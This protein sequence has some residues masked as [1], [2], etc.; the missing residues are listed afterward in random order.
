MITNDILK[1]IK[2]IEICTKRLL[3]GSLVG[4]SRSAIKGSG[5][6]FDQ[7][8]EYQIGDDVRFLDW[9]S[10]ARTGKLLVKQYIEERNRT[11]ILAVDISGSSFF[12]SSTVPKWDLF[13]QI[14]AVLTLVAEYG[15]DNVS[16]I[17]FSDELEL[18][19]PPGRGRMHIQTILHHIFSWKP[20]KKQTCISAVLK[21]LA[22][23]KRTD[24]VVFLVSDFIVHD[25]EPLL[26]VI[27]K[28]YDL[29][30]VR[31]LDR[32]EQQIPAV[33]FL[34]VE[35]IETGQQ[36]LLDTRGK[37]R[38]QLEK[39]V[40]NRIAQQNRLFKKYNIDCLELIDHKS[41][42]ADIIRFF[43]RRMMY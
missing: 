1:K 17:L 21:Q 6:E 22:K 40:Q 20:K 25:A 35:D 18:C 36:I 28:M 11:I 39:Y 41:L 43:R 9:K 8:R 7:I 19:I 42:I 5:F 32:Y 12:S 38:A 15:R 4:D 27:A 29:I 10:S 23:M 24:S 2:H 33:G 31:S 26:S 13:Q 37:N 16:L 3:S 14:V 30:A 34:H